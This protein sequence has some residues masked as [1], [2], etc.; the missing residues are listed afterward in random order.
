[1]TRRSFRL[2]NGEDRCSAHRYSAPGVA[3]V[4]TAALRLLYTTIAALCVPYL[5]LLPVFIRSNSFT[6][7][8]MSPTM[9]RTYKLLG[10][11]E[12]FDTLN[13]L[14]IAQSGYDQPSLV[15]FY[16]LYPVL[17]RLLT[18]LL[19][20]PLLAALVISTVAAFFLFWGLLVI[21][22]LDFPELIALRAVW[23]YAVWPASFIFFCGYAESLVL[24]LVVWSIYFGRSGRWWLAGVVGCLAPL[25]KAVGILVVFPLVVLAL[26]ER[27]WRSLWAAL[28]LI[29]GAAYPLW[30]HYSGR[31]LPSEAYTAYWFT[32]ISWPWTTVLHCLQAALRFLSLRNAAAP[33]DV[34]A[35]MGTSLMYLLQLTWVAIVIV[36]ALSRRFRLEYL[37]YSLAAVCTLLTK[38]SPVVLQPWIRYGLILFPAAIALPLR[39]KDPLLLGGFMALSFGFNLLLLWYF[40]QW[41]LVV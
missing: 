4:L 32:Q 15:V 33:L 29:G 40:L 3:F 30:L 20:S 41:I 39:E 5:S 22:R 21:A 27:R 24:A 9:G 11:W 35:A 2:D 6:E 28:S 8:L 16:P 36:L 19:R 13:Y 17:I 34:M 14:H 37:V 25:A 7:H 1:M 31:L 26:R 23:F 18:P 12:R 38:D 10:V